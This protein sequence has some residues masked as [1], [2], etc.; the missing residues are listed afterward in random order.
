M[1]VIYDYFGRIVFLFGANYYFG[2]PGYS[3]IILSRYHALDF[4]RTRQ[5]IVLAKF[6]IVYRDNK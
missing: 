3:S 6:N 1:T 2:A 4:L 5:N